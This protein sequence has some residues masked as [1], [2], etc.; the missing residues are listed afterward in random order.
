MRATVGTHS[1]IETL[2]LLGYA[3]VGALRRRLAS[4]LQDGRQIRRMAVLPLLVPITP[5]VVQHGSSARRG[6]GQG[7]LPSAKGR[8]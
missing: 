2:M 8:S 4:A 3:L 6:T 5:A 1:P 7:P